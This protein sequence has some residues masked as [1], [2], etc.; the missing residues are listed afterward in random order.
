[1]RTSQIAFKK[2]MAI[3]I[4]LVF[5]TLS[6]ITLLNKTAP[7]QAG[8]LTATGE[9]GFGIYLPIVARLTAT[10]SRVSVASDGTQ[11]NNDSWETAISAD[12]R[13]VAFR[14]LA[15]NLISGDTNGFPNVFVHDRQT[16]LTNRVSVASDGSQANGGSGPPSISANGRYVAFASWA[17]NLVSGDTN[18]FIDI[19]VHD[20]HTGQTS[21]VSVASDET[22]ANA[23]SYGPSISAD[24]R[25]V[26]FHSHAT[27][28][29][30]GSSFS[31]RI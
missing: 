8:T 27:N 13:Y 17:S 3:T 4:G 29:V 28:L 21:R 31:I 12:G 25:Y 11:A 24:G 19:F 22:Q 15:N 10:T 16:G 7:I 9:P 1:M 30:S 6:F 18:N 14:S 5:V 23:D 2:F 26:A 20:R